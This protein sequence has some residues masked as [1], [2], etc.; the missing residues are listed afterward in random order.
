MSV[1]FVSA[2]EDQEEISGKSQEL[3][4]Q[5]AYWCLPPT[6]EEI[7]RSMQLL[8]AARIYLFKH[9]PFFGA[10]VAR[11]RPVPTSHMN[12]Q[13]TMGVM[14]NGRL[15]YSPKFV[16]ELEEQMPVLAGALAHE[17]L[18]LA[19]DVFRRRGDRDPRLFNMA[20][21]Y[22]VNALVKSYPKLQLGKGWL[23]NE[24]YH[25]KNLTAE[26]IYDILHQEQ[27]NQKQNG[28]GQGQENPDQDN[29]LGMPNAGG[30]CDHS[31]PENQRY[32]EG[33][34]EKG[35]I[36]PEEF[37]A[38]MAE[39][40]EIAKRQGNLPSEIE[41][42]VD[43]L[44]RPSKSYKELMVE[45]MARSFGQPEMSFR[46][47]SRFT[48][49]AEGIYLPVW[50][51]VAKEATAA[52]DSSG[53]VSRAEL[54]RFASE[55][56]GMAEDAG[57]SLTLYICDCSVAE[58]VDEVR[59]IMDVDIKGFGGTSFI[60]VFQRIAER[61]MDKPCRVLFYFTDMRV[62]S[63]AFP[64]EIPSFPVYWCVPEYCQQEGHMQPPFGSVVYVPFGGE[65]ESV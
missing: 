2:T 43:T 38:A 55:L 7:A 60:P 63:S 36:T 22:V 46:R 39:A 1:A 65:E 15:I 53:S 49:E 3:A 56:E 25:K 29:P 21:D 27:E 58:E 34:Y 18:H 30:C 20:H 32:A 5:I 14:A 62:D 52:L 54:H 10:L 12:A 42:W 51:D 17:V 37:K 6:P 9:A 64:A 23:Y 11:L 31:N 50:E 19:G 61:Q 57:G 13:G 45:G 41:R 26:Q 35:D 4:K 28:G 24:E 33:K 8:A 40:K 59:S 47:T 16:N 48:D 44:F